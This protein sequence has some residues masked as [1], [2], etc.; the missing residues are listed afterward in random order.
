MGFAI[1]EDALAHEGAVVVGVHT[2][3]GEWQHVR[4]LIERPDDQ[5]L[6][7]HSHGDALGPSRGNVRHGQ[8][9]NVVAIGL[10]TTTVLDHVDLEETWRRVPPVGEGPHRNAAPDGRSHALAALALPVD[11]QARSSEHAV[12]GRCTHLQHLAPDDRVQVEM[13]VPFHRIDQDRNQRLQALAADP[14]G[15]LPEHRQRLANGLVVEA[16]ARSPGAARLLDLVA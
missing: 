12:D 16:I 11:V 1:V 10:R 4:H 3:H 14:V 7:A 8:R 2:E 13:A 6:L 15:C 9:V 5:H